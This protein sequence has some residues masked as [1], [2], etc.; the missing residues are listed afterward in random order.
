MTEVFILVSGIIGA[1]L[2]WMLGFGMSWLT[3]LVYAQA[4]ERSWS[5]P[6]TFVGVGITFLFQMFAYL[7]AGQVTAIVIQRITGA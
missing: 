6:T 4:K 3:V 7:L 1:A 2:L 5:P